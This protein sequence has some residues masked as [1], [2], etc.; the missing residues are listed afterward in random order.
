MY[1]ETTHYTTLKLHTTQ[2]ISLKNTRHLTS[3]NEGCTSCTPV[4]AMF[5]V[6]GICCTIADHGSNSTKESE[7]GAKGEDFTGGKRGA[8]S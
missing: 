5:G 7:Y 1:T 6:W 4:T 8:S 3:S 2:N